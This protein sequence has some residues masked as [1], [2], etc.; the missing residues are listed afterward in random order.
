MRRNAIRTSV[1][2]V[3]ILLLPLLVLVAQETSSLLIEGPQGQA[4][5]IQ[6]QGKNYVEV[7]E[8]A[9]I[10]GGSLRFAGNQIVL[11]LPGSGDTSSQAVQP[12]PA[13]PVGFS[14]PFLAAGIETMREI[15]EWHAALK[16]ALERGYPLSDEWF[17]NFR[18]QIQASLKHTEAVASTDMDRK[19]L[20]L[21]VNEFNNMGALTDRYLKITVG[22]DYIAP[23][24]LSS[25]P[26]E[27]KLLTCWHS[28]ESM[29]SSNQFVDDGSCQ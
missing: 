14:R 11:K 20:P 18:R 16:T 6:V 26:L 25:D 1:I 3:A 21:L 17:G 15:L 7:D 5:V 29:A 2:L 23:D 13:P 10:T 24:S 19:A 22:R 28:L 12:A 27:Q 8:L 9:R 4:K